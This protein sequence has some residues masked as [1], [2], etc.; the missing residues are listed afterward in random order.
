MWPPRRPPRM[1]STRFSPRRPSPSSADLGWFSLCCFAVATCVW[2]VLSMLLC[3]CYYMFALCCCC[4]CCC[5]YVVTCLVFVCYCVYLLLL[6]RS[7]P[8][9]RREQ[10]RQIS[11]GLSLRFMLR[12]VSRPMFT[13]RPMLQL[14]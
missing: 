6:G 12:L 10:G 5:W 11:K 2:V 3:L 9:W 1:V 14:T 7:R 4:C 13:L 8:I